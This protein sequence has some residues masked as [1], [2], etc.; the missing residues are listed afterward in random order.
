MDIRYTI[1]KNEYKRMTTEELRD[2]F[3]I[4]I[5]ET[6]KLNLLYCEV[7]RGIVG[8]A[9]PT[10]SSLSLEAG[11]ELA[12]DYFCHRREVG[13]LNIGG[14]GTVTIDGSEYNMGNLDGL[15]IGRGSKEVSF[16]SADADDPARFYMVS[17]PAHGKF[18]TTHAVKADANVLHLG[19]MEDANKRTVYQYIHENG[20]KD[21]LKFIKFGFV[22]A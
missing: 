6:G 4:S 3:L 13:V 7:E 15:Y 18:P 21:Y 16:T 14:D 19:T 8:A 2:S 1:G 17:Y 5:F 12:A 9:V 20:I 22:N 10:D 11:E